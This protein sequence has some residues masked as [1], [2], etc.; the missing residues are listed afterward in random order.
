MHE[1]INNT[2]PMFKL[3]NGSE[4]VFYTL[5]PEGQIVLRNP[6]EEDKNFSV[7]KYYIRDMGLERFICGNNIKKWD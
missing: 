3:F 2:Y 5:N 6:K 4:G 7:V 1:K